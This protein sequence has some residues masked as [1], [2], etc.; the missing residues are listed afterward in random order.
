MRTIL[1]FAVVLWALP[2]TLFGTAI[3]MVGLATG[4]GVR[5]RGR[6]V[7]FWGGAVAWFLRTFPLVSGASAVTFGH[8]I[9][10]RSVSALDRCRDHELVHVRQYERWGLLFVPAYLS[11]WVCL[12]ILG[13]D[14]YWENPFETEA[15]RRDSRDSGD[16]PGH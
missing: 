3:G 9:L 13:R 10:G 11:Y 7:E 12:W 16:S 8:C 2:W 6:T 5:H 4:G 15:F 1:T 14:P